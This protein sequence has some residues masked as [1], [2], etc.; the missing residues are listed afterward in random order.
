MSMCD[1]TFPVRCTF[2]NFLRMPHRS[3]SLLYWC[4]ELSRT[5]LGTC[6][7]HSL[8]SSITTIHTLLRLPVAPQLYDQRFICINIKLHNFTVAL[9]IFRQSLSVL[10][11]SPTASIPI[12]QPSPVHC[13]A[14]LATEKTE[15]HYIDALSILIVFRIIFVN[16]CCVHFVQSKQV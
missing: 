4:P 16:S 8:F 10:F 5:Y 6:A 11:A 9:I 3:A 14:L 7:H 2:R 12:R 1:A 15:W 13:V